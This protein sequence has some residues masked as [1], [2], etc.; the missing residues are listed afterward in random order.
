MRTVA[1]RTV[2]APLVAVL[3]LALPALALAGTRKY[4]GSFP[5]QGAGVE[6][7]V[8]TKNGH[9]KYLTLFEFHNIPT[10]C[11]TFTSAV[12]GEL[13]KQIDIGDQKKFHTT[14]HLNSGRETVV[15]HGRLKDNEQKASG[16]LRVTGT[17]PG[18]PSGDT[19]VVDWHA[20]HV[21]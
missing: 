14:G 4:N 1:R 2:I 21:Q 3:A 20:H 9:A 8:H 15:I 10:N 13:D 19:G 6:F 16:T 11:G 5:P 7:K 17:A 18:C 12:T